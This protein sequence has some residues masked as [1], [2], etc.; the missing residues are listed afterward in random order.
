M[1]EEPITRKDDAKAIE[2]I[3]EPQFNE[4]DSNLSD[5]DLEILQLAGLGELAN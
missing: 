4:S 5:N 3:D 1:E 2:R